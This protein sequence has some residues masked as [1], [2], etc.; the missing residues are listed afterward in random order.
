[1][2]FAPREVDRRIRSLLPSGIVTGSR[3][4]V[5]DVIRWA[6]HETCKDIGHHLPYWAQQGL[7]HHKRLAAYK[8]YRSSG[9]FAALRNSWLQPE[10]QT[11]EEM[12]WI[13]SGAKMSA[14]INTVPLLRE[15][16]ERLGVTKLVNSS[17]AEEQEH[18]VHYEVEPGSHNIEHPRARPPKVQ[19]APAQHVIH[20]DILEF[21]E[22][23]KV[24]K[25]STHISPLLVPLNMARTLNST[26]E[27]SPSPLA[28]ADFISTTLDS[29]G[30]GLTEYLRPVNWILSS[31]S[32]KKST[33]V[34]ISPYEANELLPI[35][36]KSDRVRLHIYAPRVTSSMRSFSD[37]TFYT[38][39]ERPDP[40][41]RQWSAPAHVRME[42]NL[43]AGQLY[44]DSREEYEGICALLALSMAHPKA[45]YSEVDGFVPP[46]YRTGRNSPFARSRI[47]LLK[48]LIELRRKGKGYYLTH[49]GQVLNGKPLSEE[50]L[51]ALSG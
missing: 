27:W 42:L 9:D 44:F 19:P 46:A 8:E 43:F 1:M 22:S 11:L 20:A 21:V 28:T 15:R 7:D 26:A 39:P 17:I 37:L 23:G 29:D 6:V 5:L 31:G 16:M 50:T 34:V 14:D 35:I 13:R 12:Y 25:F 30:V 45:E 3:I 49:L 48:T 32:G 18:E 10:S 47:P 36:C 33:V 4:E 40:Q 24:P 41:T 38:I 51:S 2:F